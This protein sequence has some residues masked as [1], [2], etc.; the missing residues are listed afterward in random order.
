MKLTLW[1]HGVDKLDLGKAQALQRLANHDDYLVL[2][3]LI[4]ALLTQTADSLQKQDDSRDLYRLQGE[5][6]GY[7]RVMQ[8]LDDAQEFLSNQKKLRS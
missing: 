3:S 4:H 5:C 2:H 6:R 7:R 8:L 1:V